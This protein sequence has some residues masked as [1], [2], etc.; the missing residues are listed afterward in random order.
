M[1]TIELRHVWHR[2]HRMTTWALEDVSAELKADRIILISGH[3]GGGKTT[4]LKIAAL[5][6]RPLRGEVVTNGQ[7]F[8]E[9]SE[10]ERIAIR[11]RI[12]YVHERPILIRGSVL[13]NIAY[14]LRIRRLDSRDAARRME[15]VMGELELMELADKS[16]KELSAGQSQLVA[17]ARALVAEPELILLDEPFAHLD[18]KRSE[19]VAVAL[20]ERR[21]SGAGIVIASH[22][23]GDMPDGLEPDEVIVL[24]EGRIRWRRQYPESSER[25]EE[26]N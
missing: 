22:G 3:N 25:R 9:M 7:S 11:R 1:M 26:K 24:E 23:R 8:W 2:Y 16:A 20:Q 15:K 18:S 19:L 10:A 12:A 13:E 5:L 4:L 17:I 21:A 14:P 6:Y